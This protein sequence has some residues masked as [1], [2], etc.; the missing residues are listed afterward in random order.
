MAQLINVWI[1]KEAIELML[2][3]INNTNA[4][5][6]AVDVSVNN[7]ANNYGQNVAVSVAQPKEDRDAKKPK[8]YVGNGKTVWSNSGEFIPP[9][10]NK[11]QQQQQ[12]E[13]NQSDELPF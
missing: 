7:E 10:D 9:K 5:G 13:T 8:Y 1:K 6:I 3:K 2:K 12:P 4:T 11:Q